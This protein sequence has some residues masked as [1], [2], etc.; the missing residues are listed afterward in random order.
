MSGVR[1]QWGRRRKIPF[2]VHGEKPEPGRLNDY[3][4]KGY[5]A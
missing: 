1:L 5:M 2:F 3:R 4:K